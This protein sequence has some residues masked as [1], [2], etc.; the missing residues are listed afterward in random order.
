MKHGSQRVRKKLPRL[1]GTHLGLGQGQNSLA[2]GDH[3][4]SVD[5]GENELTVHGRL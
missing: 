3:V 1:A 2:C 5:S 4:A